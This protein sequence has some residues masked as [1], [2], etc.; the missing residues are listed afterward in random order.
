MSI[1][2]AEVYFPIHQFKLYRIKKFFFFFIVSSV[3]A[4]RNKYKKENLLHYFL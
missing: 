4:I 2:I 3:F 1:I